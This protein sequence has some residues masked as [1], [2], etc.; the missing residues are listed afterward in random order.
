M[1]DVKKVR[2][3]EFRVSFPNVFEPVGF[4]GSPPK[5]S[6][7]ML[8]DKGTDISALKKEAYKAAQEKWGDKAKGMVES[9]KVRMP[10]RDGDEDK[11]DVD[12]YKNCV[13]MN[14]SSKQKPGLVDQDVNPIMDKN[15]F[16][17]GCYAHAT[18]KPFAYDTAGNKGVS[19]GLQNIQFIRD[20]DS[21]SGRSRAEDD[22]APA[23]GAK[24]KFESDEDMWS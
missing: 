22:F 6:I 20:G 21:F 11:P 12:G 8:F 18:V 10:F 7:C 24:E 14:C 5:Y 2:T 19:F 17:A 9:G 4:N 23:E 13:F 16:Y 1:S 3:P 15:D